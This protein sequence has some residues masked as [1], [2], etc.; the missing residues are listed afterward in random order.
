MDCLV[1][2]STNITFC[3]RTV[4]WEEAASAEFCND[5]ELSGT[6]SR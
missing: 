1:P 5:F 2:T 6:L 4:R 3:G